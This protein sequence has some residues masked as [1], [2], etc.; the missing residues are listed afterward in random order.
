M[1]KIVINRRQTLLLGGAAIAMPAIIPS[2]GRAATEALKIGVLVPTTGVHASDGIRMLKSHQLAAKLINESGGIK[3]LGGTKIELLVVDIQSKPE[4]SR[5]EAERLISRERVSALTGAWASATTIP[6]AQISERNRTPFMITSAVNDALTEQGMKYVFRTAVKAKWFGGYIADF[7]DYQKKKGV[8]V[9]KIGLA[10]E[11]GPAGQAVHSNYTSV[12]PGRGFPIVS[13]ETF[14]TGTADFSTLAT[15]LRTSGADGLLT[16]AY[17]E[18]STVLLRALAA[19]NFRPLY[20]GFGGAHV[21]QTVLAAGKPSDRTFGVVEWAPD[22]KKPAS[23]AFV[24]A[25]GEAHPGETPLSNQAQ[26]FVATYALALA[27][28]AAKS[29]DREAIREALRSLKIK[30]GPASVLPAPELSFDEQGQSP[31]TCVM[32]QAIDGKFV[33]IWPE[34]VAAQPPA[35]IQG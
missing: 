33:T 23:L 31:A 3:S 19:Q 8:T 2:R 25:F 29:T 14:R 5:A 9:N 28:D 21:N 13:D 20:V 32:V 6:A 7:L 18:D 1:T 22:L 15:K 30:D 17:A 35:A 26:A 27:A 16:C 34:A 12:M 4:V 10:T 24:K 11:D